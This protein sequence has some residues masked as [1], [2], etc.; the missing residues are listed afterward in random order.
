[1]RRRMGWTWST[2]PEAVPPVVTMRSAE[3][4]V[5][6]L[7]SAFASSPSRRTA[8][9]SAPSARSQDGSIGPSA[10]R[11]SPSRAALR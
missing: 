4:P 7:C 2:G 6:A 9:T 5:M 10:S 11:M 3:L 1:M 8:V